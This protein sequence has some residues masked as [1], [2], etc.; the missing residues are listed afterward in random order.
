MRERDHLLAQ[1]RKDSETLERKEV[2]IR[3]QYEEQ[4]SDSA[5]KISQVLIM[6]C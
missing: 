6:F 5:M 2:V 3:A 4:L 1:A